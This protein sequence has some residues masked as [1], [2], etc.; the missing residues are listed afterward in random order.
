MKK[1]TLILFVLFSWLSHGQTCTQYFDL[2][3]S[4]TINEDYESLTITSNDAT[5]CSVGTINSITITYVE[6]FDFNSWENLCGA[7]YSF[8]LDLD[9][10]ITTVCYDELIGMDLT[11]FNS[12]TITVHDMDDSYDFVVL[13]L[14]IEVNFTPTEIPPCLTGLTAPSDL[15]QNA[16]DGIIRWTASPG[17]T[18][19]N[20]AV[21]TT[22][23][24]GETVPWMDAG[25]VTSY[26]IPGTLE[27]GTTYFVSV[28]P[29][30]DLGEAEDCS[31]F[32]FITP[33][34]ITN[35][36]CETAIDLGDLTSPL[37]SSTVGALNDNLTTC[38]NFNTIISNS[39]GDVYYSILVPDNHTLRIGQTSND[40]DSSNI[41]FYGDCDNR[42]QIVCFD[43]PD[44]RTIQ[45]KNETGED[46]TV[47]WIQDGHSGVGSFTLAWTVF[48]C[49][50]PEATYSTHSLCTEDNEGFEMVTTITSLG[51]ATSVTVSD[52]H[53][54]SQQASE[55]G[56][57]ILGPYANNTNVIIT[58]VNDD[59][60]TCSITSSTF[61]QAVCPPS[62][63]SCATAIDLGNE[64][65]PISAT[66][67]GSVNNNMTTCNNSNE[68]ITNN[69]PDVYYYITVPSGSTL[70]IG[71]TTN[72]YDSSNIVF[73][74][75]CN[76]RTQIDC[77]D[78]P[79]D[80]TVVWANN[81]GS[82][83]NVYWIQDGHSG[84]GSFTLAWSVIACTSPTATYSVV[85]DCENGDQ[86]MVNVNV[87]SLG[88]ATSVTVSDDQGS[89]IET[90][91]EEG[92]VVLGPYPNNT[93]LII[94]V[95]NDDDSD[96][97][98]TSE[99]LNQTICPPSND[100]CATAI[101][102]GNE[103]SPLEGTTL[104]ASNTNLNTCNNLGGVITTNTYP[105][106]Y[107][108]IIVPDGSTLEIGQTANNYDST[109]VIFYGD[110]DNRT[111]I[112][113]FDDPDEKT[114][115][116]VNDTGSNQ[117]VYWIQD[118]HSGTGD[119]TL[120]WSVIEN[121]TRP[122]ATYSVVS[123]C[124]NGDQFMVN[125]DVTSL[126]SATSVTVFDNQGMFSETASGEGIVIMGPYPN[127]TPL[128]FTV[129]SNDNG[130]CKAISGTLTLIS[131]PPANDNC[132]GAEELIVNEDLA[133]GVV[134]PGTVVG[135]TASVVTGN[136]CFGNADDD[137]WYSFVATS[138]SHRISI[139]NVAGSATDMFHSLWTGDCDSLTLVPGSCSDPNISNPS[140][141]I[142]G[143]TYYVRVYT[144]TATGGQTTTFDIC[145]GTPPPPPGN[146]ECIGAIA[147]IPGSTYEENAVDADV[148]FA[149]NSANI[150]APGCANYSGGDIWY[151][152]VI[153]GD[154][155]ITIETGDASDGSNEFD[156]GIAA[157]SGS[158]S[159]GLTLMQNAASQNLCDDD[160]AGGRYSRLNITNRTPGE[161]IYI[162]VWEYGNDENEL[163]SIS[164][165]SAT[166]N[167]SSFKTEN[168]KVYPNP[169]KDVLNIS[170]TQ[171]ITNVEVYNML[172]QQ[173]I[174]KT[175]NANQ[176][177]ID[178]SNLALGTYL[179]KVTADSQT[180]TIKVIK[181]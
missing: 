90:A 18:G 129:E 121:C 6:I 154:G 151:S 75:D 52:N 91:A 60:L 125:V 118:G 97:K 70:K 153:P 71:Q 19:Y 27:L 37:F 98:A 148:S 152:V 116:W 24:G 84:S 49:T 156:S 14:D 114:V 15:S 87:T 55:T 176:G 137:V 12:L 166:L 111:Q 127:N 143:Q 132:S 105:D 33:G 31:E 62:N 96:C 172:G 112:D 72:D 63:Y 130:N 119:F 13:F 42:T 81:T 2:W 106:V 8:E 26:D 175:V 78:D 40:Y 11:G 20:I 159:E 32:S 1:I 163:F 47:Y 117:T 141:L 150:P 102:L 65:S 77:F 38:N 158:C 177:Q 181:Q 165:W 174:T 51:S 120:A 179:V 138:V 44:D 128:I 160:G 140:G 94:T 30:N 113:C 85:S 22:P 142:I 123:D 146:D 139:L 3:S 135:A 101:D 178:M 134:S 180:N 162:R 69:H 147:L 167:A 144:Y 170:Y 107:Y 59:E 45:W 100:T 86:F 58:I 5:S 35:E 17:V 61:N 103:I 157:Y 50:Q 88:S 73:Y 169:V 34:V 64:T 95:E 145:I 155:K 57:V 43:D 39:Y 136:T 126:G 29:Y 171:N 53:G 173:V 115:V 131:C 161:T 124:E 66:T 4:D 99:T 41:V 104:G 23:G 168:F 149:T 92:I 122:E 7:W 9:G 48:A 46:Q 133:C 74:G 79:D 89:F 54:N 82:D 67:V 16:L 108:S 164:A 80:K 56:P 28:I 109:N 25:N 76:N 68:Q 110:C 93:P 10:T 36:T 83:Q 21:G